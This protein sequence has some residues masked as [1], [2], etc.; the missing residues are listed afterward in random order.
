MVD[1]SDGF[2]F[3]EKA[4]HEH[5]VGQDLGIH[6]LECYIPIDQFIA[7][8]PHRSARACADQP[9]QAIS[10]VDQI[11]FLQREP[12]AKPTTLRLSM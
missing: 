10:R 1:P 11:S 12:K 2:G 3:V 5:I 7:R 8:C 6:D 9:Q 4:L